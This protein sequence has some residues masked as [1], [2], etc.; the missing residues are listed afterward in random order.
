M[1]NKKSELKCGIMYVLVNC[2]QKEPDHC[3]VL[4]TGKT[5]VE[6]IVNAQL[7]KNVD[8]ELSYSDITKMN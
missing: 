8:P 2:F 7:S 6:S 4:G 5:K 1:T 3:I